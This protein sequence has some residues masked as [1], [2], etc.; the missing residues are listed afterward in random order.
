MLCTVCTGRGAGEAGARWN[1]AAV[2]SFE[3]DEIGIRLAGRFLE[4]IEKKDSF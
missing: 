1:S 4:S 2:W 3:G